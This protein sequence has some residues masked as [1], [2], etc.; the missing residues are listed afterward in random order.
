M[1]LTF[2]Q[3]KQVTFG[4]VK[5]YE[6]EDGV[7]FLKCTEKQTAAWNKQD[8]ILGER[9]LACTGISLDFHTNS[10]SL[11]FRVASGCKYE[12][13]VDGLLRRQFKLSQEDPTA[14]LLLNDPLGD[15]LDEKRVT[16]YLPA[17][18]VA[19]L[20]EVELDNGATLTPHVF[21]RKFLFIGDSITQGWA[22]DYDSLSYACRTAR[23]FN[24]Q[25]VNQGIGG[26]YFN[27]EAFDRI[28]YDPDT[29]FVSYGTND[30]GHY[31]TYD[32][33]R[34]HAAAHLG[35]IAEEYAGKKIFVISPIWRDL[36]AEKKMGSFAG[37]RQ[38]IA[39]EAEKLGLIHINGLKLVPPLN[40]FYQ[41][42]NLH[43][44]DNGFSLY[45]ENLI[46]EV[47]KYM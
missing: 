38:V 5:L 43:P 31:K 33:L 35:L 1:K 23:F 10:K 7:H 26:S 17:H 21:D 11:S 27:E 14:T 32:E 28:N 39:E 6:K 30:Y 46:L 12:V 20:T 34:T 42:R 41:D 3:I 44:D 24:A 25:T 4:A 2:E 45:A 19:V 13:Y 18:D 37:C 22:A 8:P 40:A 15:G 47:Q 16:L 29:V 36:A 9:S